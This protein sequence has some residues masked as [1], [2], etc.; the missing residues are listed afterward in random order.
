[1]AFR[2]DLREP[3]FFLHRYPRPINV[4]SNYSF[5]YSSSSSSFGGLGLLACSNSELI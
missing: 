4:V 1:M 2:V 3:T 5:I